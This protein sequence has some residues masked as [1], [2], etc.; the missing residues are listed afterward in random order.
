MWRGERRAAVSRVVVISSTFPDPDNHCEETGN[1]RPGKSE[2]R[3]RPSRHRLSSLGCLT[4]MAR[5]RRDHQIRR[6]HFAPAPCT[7]ASQQDV[8]MA[9]NTSRLPR[10]LRR[11]LWLPKCLWFLYRTRYRRPRPAEGG[12]T[13]LPALGMNPVESRAMTGSM[14][15]LLDALPGVIQGAV[16]AQAALPALPVHPGV[17]PP[18]V[19]AGSVDPELYDILNGVSDPAPGTY[20]PPADTVDVRIRR[21]TVD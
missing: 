13:R 16:A 4:M 2:K 8:A 5:S 15:A 19:S 9:A 11:L 18:T 1:R 17:T 12:P 20:T 6:P 10:L 7:P 21:S 3:C 14:L